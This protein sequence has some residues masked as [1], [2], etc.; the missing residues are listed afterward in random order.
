MTRD[1]GNDAVVAGRTSCSRAGRG[2]AATFRGWNAPTG[3]PLRGSCATRGCVRD[4]EGTDETM[5]MNP[6]I[7]H[8]RDGA[9]R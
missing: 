7:V 6:T 4:P 1:L 3:R 2:V 8:G 5:S 9:A